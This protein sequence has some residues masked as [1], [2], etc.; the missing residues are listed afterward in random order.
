MF[1]TNEVIE[2]SI[3]PAWLH[4][5]GQSRAIVKELVGC[6]GTKS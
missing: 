5:T 6:V 4:H 3:G 1:K 2:K